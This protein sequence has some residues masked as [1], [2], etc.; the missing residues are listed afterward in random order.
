M[1]KGVSLW[2]DTAEKG[3]MNGNYDLNLKGIERIEKNIVF[4]P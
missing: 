1:V 2:G 3:C 4:V